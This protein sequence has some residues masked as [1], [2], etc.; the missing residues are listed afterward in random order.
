MTKVFIIEIDCCADCP[1]K[2]DSI[3]VDD[4]SLCIY[5]YPYL[6]LADIDTLTQIHPLCPL[7]DITGES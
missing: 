4:R 2:Q 6:D 1:A 3:A 5:T 7:Q